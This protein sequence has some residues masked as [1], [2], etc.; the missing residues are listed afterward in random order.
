MTGPAKKASQWAGRA[1]RGSPLLIRFIVWVARTIGRGTARLL[2][3]P[4]SLY[5]LIMAP[6]ARRHSRDYLRR[7]DGDKAGIAAI[8]GHIHCFAATILDRVFFLTDRFDV[9]DLTFDGLEA[10]DRAA[11]DGR[12]AI[13]L[14]AH[15]GSFD[16]MRALAR[17]RPDLRLKVL[18]HEG[19]DGR[20]AAALN[21]IN[22]DLADTVIPLGRPESMLR[23]GEWLRGGGAIGILGDRVPAGDKTVRLPFL[24][25][26]ARFPISP[27]ILASVTGAPVVMF[28]GVYQGGNR[29]MIRFR[30]LAE[31]VRRVR[32]GDP[33]AVATD[34]TRYVE[35][36]EDWV[37]DH[38]K[39]WFNFYDFWH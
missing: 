33:A 14:G 6:N 8:Y 38:P 29:Y 12:G 19:P 27:W 9:F 20:V 7:I 22:P 2:L 28:A 34:L 23:V 26:G 4:I 24:G 21:R 32:G 31:C 18:M 11:A 15:F 30:Y 25:E 5:F 13:L 39:N 37:R 10:I 3:H 36:L 16:A 1:E 17:K 35:T